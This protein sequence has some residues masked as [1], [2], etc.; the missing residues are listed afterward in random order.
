MKL[1]DNMSLKM[2]CY[3]GGLT[4][5]GLLAPFIFYFSIF[6]P[7]SDYSLARNDQAWANFGSFIG[8]TIGPILSLFAFLGVLLTIFIQKRQFDLAKEQF[9]I[10]KKT[11][12]E[13][14][15][16]TKA[17]YEHVKTQQLLSDLLGIIS[18][19]CNDIYFLF[20]DKDKAPVN[21]QSLFK[22]SILMES[23]D[24]NSDKYRKIQNSSLFEIKLMRQRISFLCHTF[25]LY[26]NKNG[27]KEIIAMYRDYIGVEVIMFLSANDITDDEFMDYFPVHTINEMVSKLPEKDNF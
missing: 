15:E 22:L 2:K 25:N 27:N 11:L 16:I 14:L 7:K 24:K 4:A 26:K 9:E 21:F 3:L 6:G 19:T 17:Q 5:S 20:H 13:D 12:N 10:T 18:N 8:G 1:I 23:M